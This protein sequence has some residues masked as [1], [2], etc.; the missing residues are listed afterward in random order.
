MVLAEVAVLPLTVISTGSERYCVA[1]RRMV[2]GIVAENSATCLVSG[3]SARIRSTSSAK[4]M[5][6][7]SSASSSTR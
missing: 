2:F 1:S 3:V 4:P 7:I 6:S 5:L